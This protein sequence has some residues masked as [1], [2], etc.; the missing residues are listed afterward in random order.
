MT[1]LLVLAG[2]SRAW[3]QVDRL[4]AL[5][6]ALDSR[7]S[8]TETLRLWCVAHRPNAV[9]SIHAARDR[10]DKAPSPEILRLLGSP[11]PRQ[12]RFRHVR[13]VCG[14]TTLSVA[15]NW[16]RAD[17]LSAAMN[18]ALDDT[19]A[20][21]GP[22]VAPLGLHRHAL[23]NE[24]LPATSGFVLKR[25]AVLMNDRSEPFSV[26]EETYTSAMLENP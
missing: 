20:P 6:R 3:A 21:F 13:L 24:R 5:E 1:A 18:L 25:R 19:D 15:D 9:A 14:G 23:S 22:V 12:I 17:R 16:Y 10:L 26:V 4:G 11:D 8:A 2:V 7:D